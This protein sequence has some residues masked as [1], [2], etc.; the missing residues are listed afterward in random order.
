VCFVALIPILITQ[1]DSKH[2]LNINVKERPYNSPFM[3][4]HDAFVVVFVGQNDVMAKR[5]VTHKYVSHTSCFTPK[6]TYIFVI[7]S[8]NELE[9]FFYLQNNLQIWNAIK[10]EKKHF[11][12]I[13]LFQN[14]ATPFYAIKPNQ[15]GF[16]DLY[17]R[18]E[19]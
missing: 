18:H 3:N 19:N 8:K 11:S 10:K 9:L 17:S 16:S 14:L 5:K 15:I 6:L 13:H 2:F 4:R 7:N 1:Y 12:Y